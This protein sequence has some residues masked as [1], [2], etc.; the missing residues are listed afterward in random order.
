M[1]ATKFEYRARYWIHAVIY[2]LGFWSPWLQ[3]LDMRREYTWQVLMNA[4]AHLGWLSFNASAV[5][6]LVIATIFAALGGWLRI[7]GTAY[8]GSSVVKSSSMH[9]DSLLAD[10]PYRYLRNPLYLG[11]LLHTFGV[12]LIMPPSGAIFT[13]VLIWIFQIRLAVAEEPFLLARF[14]ESYREY[15]ARVRRF[16]PSLTPRVPSAGTQPHWLQS[17]VGEVY[18]VGVVATFVIFGWTY[19]VETLIRGVVISLGVS[20]I[21]RAFLPKPSQG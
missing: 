21:V 16:V 1:G 5:V 19:N 14:G 13:I 2:I 20:L 12:A 18:M 17:A 8:V 7:W 15:A 11:T 9:G 4:T 10:G 6:W 3:L